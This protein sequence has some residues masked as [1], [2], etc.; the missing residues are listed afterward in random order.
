MKIEQKEKV[1]IQKILNNRNKTNVIK[2]QLIPQE[3]IQGVFIT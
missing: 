1:K 2:P 3:N